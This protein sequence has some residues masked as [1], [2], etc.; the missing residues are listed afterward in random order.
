[1]PHNSTFAAARHQECENARV[2]AYRG[3]SA[4]TRPDAL[5][6]LKCAVSVEFWGVLEAGAIV[7]VY[8][9][10]VRYFGGRF[11]TSTFELGGVLIPALLLCKPYAPLLGELVV[12][13]AT[14]NLIPANSGTGRKALAK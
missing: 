14:G 10:A 13:P 7:E 1:M 4:T 6:I 8:G 5:A 11:V 12:S 3:H 2:A 9:D